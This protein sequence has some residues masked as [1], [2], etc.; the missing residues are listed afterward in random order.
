[1]SVA[2]YGVYF[3]MFLALYFEVFLLISFFEKPPPAKNS[4]RPKYFPTAAIIVPVWNEERTLG[5]TIESLLALDYPKDR[6]SIIVVNDG[7]TDGTM[8][9]A[10]TFADNPQV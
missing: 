2:V 5:G 7:S 9:V 3:F 10:N 8:A 4:R 6:L 1:M